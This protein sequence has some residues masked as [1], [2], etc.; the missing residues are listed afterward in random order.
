M[1]LNMH[2]L[3]GTVKDSTASNVEINAKEVPSS[4]TQTY[5]LIYKILNVKYIKNITLMF[6]HLVQ[7]VKHGHL[8]E[9]SLLPHVPP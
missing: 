7:R 6:H 2:Y 3:K 8:G 9:V 1:A 5:F 4:F